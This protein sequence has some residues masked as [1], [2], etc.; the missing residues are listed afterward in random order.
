MPQLEVVEFIP[1]D[2]VPW[3]AGDLLELLDS[4]NPARLP[5]AARLSDETAPVT[6][7]DGSR[8]Y[9]Y[10]VLLP[11][12]G[13]E[14]DYVLRVDALPKQNLRL[15]LITSQREL[16]RLG[17]LAEAEGIGRL[18]LP[19]NVFIATND[20]YMWRRRDVSEYFDVTYTIVEKAD[21]G[22]NL[23]NHLTDPDYQDVLLAL[24]RTHR[25]YYQ[26]LFKGGTALYD[27]SGHYQYSLSGSLYDIS[28]DAGNLPEEIGED[29]NALRGWVRQLPFSEERRSLLKDLKALQRRYPL[30]EN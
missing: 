15:K 2:Q 6:P 9:Q 20:P 8:S 25:A 29:I 11:N 3:G 16:G 23:R 14:N 22:Q 10:N 24:A 4:Q 18:I 27:A 1:D 7:A 19:H 28:H 30:V 12:I 13:T 17:R 26:G 5:N 21:D